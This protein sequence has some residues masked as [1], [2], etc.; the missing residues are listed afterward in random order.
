[1]SDFTHGRFRHVGDTRRTYV[2]WTKL[3]FSVLEQIATEEIEQP[4]PFD[5][6][7]ATAGDSP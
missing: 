2:V 6:P 7:G 4:A 3:E 5:A 1:M